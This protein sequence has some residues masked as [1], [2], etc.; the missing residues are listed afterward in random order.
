MRLENSGAGIPTKTSIA[1]GPML[2]EVGSQDVNG[3]ALYNNENMSNAHNSTFIAALFNLMPSITG[4]NIWKGSVR[5]GRNPAFFNNTKKK[6]GSLEEMVTASDM[7]F[8]CWAIENYYDGVKAQV[9]RLRLDDNDSPSPHEKYKEK[10]RW[11]ANATKKFGGWTDEGKHRWNYI[12][13]TIRLTWT[14]VQLVEGNGKHS[15]IQEFENHWLEKF[16]RVRLGGINQY[17]D[18][19]ELVADDDFD[20]ESVRQTAET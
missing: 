17:D 8:V 5:C 3:D 18:E 14:E 16:S 11:G 20:W 6:P 1:Q 7:A 10:S 4:M 13:K 15:F 9:Y 12:R 2:L 19:D